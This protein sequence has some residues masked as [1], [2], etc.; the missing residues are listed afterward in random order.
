M[1]H[2]LA[3]AFNFTPALFFVAVGLALVPVAVALVVVALATVL[4]S[5]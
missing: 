1:N 2:V 5:T 4:A 3:R